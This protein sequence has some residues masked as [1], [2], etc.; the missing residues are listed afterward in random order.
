MSGL[1]D[2]QSLAFGSSCHYAFPKRQIQM[3]LKDLIFQPEL[4]HLKGN[5]EIA[6]ILLKA[7]WMGKQKHH[8]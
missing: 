2:K 4:S 1:E 5:R 6:Q 8:D 7:R 3:A